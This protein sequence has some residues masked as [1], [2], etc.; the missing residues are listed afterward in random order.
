MIQQAR[1]SRSDGETADRR[2]SSEK[3][4]RERERMSLTS[5]KMA[6]DV[7]LTCPTHALSID[8]E[9]I[10]VLLL[11]DIQLSAITAANIQFKNTMDTAVDV[12]QEDNMKLCDL[13]RKIS[14]SAGERVEASNAD[15]DDEESTKCPGFQQHERSDR[16]TTKWTMDFLRNRQEVEL[17]SGGFGILELVD[18]GSNEAGPSGSTCGPKE[19]DNTNVDREKRKQGRIVHR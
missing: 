17:Q 16:A 5:V 3:K 11:G 9:E 8:T 14:K 12:E 1:F 18:G 2:N 10:M 6:E 19:D 7:W 4:S 13:V 15:N